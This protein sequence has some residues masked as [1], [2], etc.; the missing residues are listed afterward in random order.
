MRAPIFFSFLGEFA[1]GF[2]GCGSFELLFAG[3][4]EVWGVFFVVPIDVGMSHF[5]TSFLPVFREG[6]KLNLKSKFNAGPFPKEIYL[7]DDE[8]F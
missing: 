7:C 6:A 8:F 4:G 1:K 5:V 2:A 3:W